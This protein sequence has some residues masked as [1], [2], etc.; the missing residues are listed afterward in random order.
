MPELLKRVGR[1]DLLEV[2]GRG[3][4]AVV[5]L[6][7]QRDLHRHVAL[8]E[9]APFHLAD[10]SF[11]ERFVEESRLAGAMNHANVV[12]VHEYFKDGEVPYIAMEYLPHGSLRQYIGRVSMAQIAGVLEGVLAGL[13][14]GETHRIVHRDLKPENLLVAIDGRVKIADFGVAR[15]Y[16]RAATRAVVTVAGTTIGTPAYMSPEQALGTDLTPATDL[17]SLGVVAWELLTG[18]VPFEEA[19]TPVAVLYRHVHEPVPSVRTVA[20]EVDERVAQWLERM[21]AK[22]PQDRFQG[23]DEAWLAL[24]DVVLE[25]LGP[26]W[27]REA[28]L[29][30]EGDVSPDQHTLTPA[31]FDRPEGDASNPPPAPAIPETVSGPVGGPAAEAA[32]PTVAPAKRGQ[33]SNTTMF[34]IARRHR[35]FG[36]DGAVATPESMRRRLVALAILV[37]MAVAAAGGVLL[38]GAGQGRTA[39]SKAARAAAAARTAAGQRAATSAAADT[40]LAAIAQRLAVAR[41]HALTRLLHATTPAVQSTE[42]RAVQAAYTAAAGRVAPLTGR[43]PAAAPLATAFRAAAGAYDQLARA[44]AHNNPRDWARA[45]AAIKVDETRL[46]GQVGKL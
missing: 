18:R 41:A 31:R 14:H 5:Y 37:A 39:P 26:R 2:I 33:R 7:L 20:P 13:A 17:Y 40:H 24:E 6:A 12:T 45:E 25:L 11:A 29:I 15:A 43:T 27:R 38:A 30:V 21:L 34:R 42:A 8:K 19:D 23:A 46:R 36:E 10:A 3:G 16:S 44:A 1:F 9:L 22:R 32:K 4:A 28:R 35:D